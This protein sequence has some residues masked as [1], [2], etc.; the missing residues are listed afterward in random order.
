MT[1]YQCPKCDSHETQAL[2]HPDCD[3]LHPPFLLATC[4][5]CGHEFEPNIQATRRTI[6]DNMPALIE[7]LRRA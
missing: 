3:G 4:D 5:D 1:V 6:F 7:E 2:P